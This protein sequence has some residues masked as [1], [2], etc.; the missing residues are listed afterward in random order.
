MSSDIFP[1]DSEASEQRREKAMTKLLTLREAGESFGVSPHTIRRWAR[2]GKLPVVRL[3][4]RT[5]RFRP[6]DL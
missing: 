2:L 6:E 1:A 4:G 3:G 5:I